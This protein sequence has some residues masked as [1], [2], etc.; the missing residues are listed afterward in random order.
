M[1]ERRVALDI[2]SRDKGQGKLHSGSG[3]YKS[4]IG[5]TDFRTD[6]TFVTRLKIG[7]EKSCVTYYVPV[8]VYL[9]SSF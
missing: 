7:R 5:S 8:V 9:R 4:H 3:G 1:T 6:K 2:G